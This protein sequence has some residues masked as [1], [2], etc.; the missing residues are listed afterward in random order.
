MSGGRARQEGREK[1]K[2]EEPIQNGKEEGKG[3][4]QTTLSS[5][6][7]CFV[8]Q[9]TRTPPKNSLK[10][11]KISSDIRLSRQNFFKKLV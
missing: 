6:S 9:S 7:L 11:L 3:D 8:F 2:E 5:I 1:E 10:I 4:M